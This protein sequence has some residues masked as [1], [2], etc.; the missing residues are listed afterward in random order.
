MWIIT[1]GSW[2]WVGYISQFGLLILPTIFLAARRRDLEISY[3]TA[4]LALMLAANLLDMIPNATL[5]P[6]TW[7]IGGA[8]AGRYAVAPR[9]N[10]QSSRNEQCAERAT[11][12]C[13]GIGAGTSS[14]PRPHRG[15]ARFSRSG[16]VN[17]S[18]SRPR[19]T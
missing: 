13:S 1:I 9:R 11:V 4:G 8:L 5:T 7:L 3:A 10:R 2:G 15:K 17:D 12:S 18:R 16:P 6:L 14:L 19:S